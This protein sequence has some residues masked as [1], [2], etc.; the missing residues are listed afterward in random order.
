M[1]LPSHLRAL[2]RLELCRAAPLLARVCGVAAS[3]AAL[4]VAT[5]HATAENLISSALGT[6][7]A[8][9]MI[10]PLLVV[11]DKLEGTIEVLRGLPTSYEAVAAAKLVSAAVCT[12]PAALQFALTAA[13]VAGAGGER[14]PALAIQ[15]F[16]TAWALLTLVAW[17]LVGLLTRYEIEQLSVAPALALA[18][19]VV[20]VGPAVE[21]AVPDP[22]AAMRWL[23]GQPWTGTLLG[24]FSVAVA[25]AAGGAAFWLTRTGL[26]EYQAPRLRVTGA[27]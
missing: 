7:V 6:G 21:R 5:G 15:G 27:R 19:L 1:I 22:V 26:A 4:F 25:S 14:T 9:A 2:T 17:L 10:G 16:V 24:A 23:A 11:R 18:L 20:V 8:F 13:W 12:A 3:A